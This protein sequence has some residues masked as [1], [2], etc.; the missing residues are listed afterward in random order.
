MF[1]GACFRLRQPRGDDPKTLTFILTGPMVTG[2]CG[3]T[4]TAT[5]D[6][7]VLIAG[8]ADNYAYGFDLRASAE[9]YDPMTGTFSATGS[10]AAA[11][12]LQTA[13]RLS[14]GSVL[15]AGGDSQSSG[16]AA[17]ALYDPKTGTFSAPGP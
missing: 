11:R 14:D 7:R 2:R 4:A 8:G 16:L 10:M 15:V 3:Y 5:G 6:G 1:V 12:I 17:A 13:T 9:L